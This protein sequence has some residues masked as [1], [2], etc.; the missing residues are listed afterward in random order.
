MWTPDYVA[1]VTFDGVDA[2]AHPDLENIQSAKA[3]ALS[4]IHEITASRAALARLFSSQT[5]TWLES[6]LRFALVSELQKMANADA[7]TSIVVSSARAELRKSKPA[8]GVSAFS[9]DV[10]LSSQYNAELQIKS[11]QLLHT[12]SRRG[13]SPPHY[14]L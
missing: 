1:P 7:K 3:K 13:G 6:E 10:S 12:V 4:C 11:L 9:F 5:A 14:E 8:S 2:E